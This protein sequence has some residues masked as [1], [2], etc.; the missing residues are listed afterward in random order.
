MTPDELAL[1]PG[2]KAT[3]RD[4]LGRVLNYYNVATD[5]GFVVAAADLLGSTSINKTA[6]SFPADSTIATPIP[7]RASSPSAEFVKTP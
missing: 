2:T 3:L 7:A 4:E 6:E 5:G 1:K